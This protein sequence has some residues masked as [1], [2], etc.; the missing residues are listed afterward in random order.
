MALGFGRGSFFASL[1]PRK[2]RVSGLIRP[3]TRPSLEGC[4]SAFTNLLEIEPVFGEHGGLEPK[5][6]T[7]SPEGKCAWIEVYNSIEAKLARNGD[8]DTIRDAASK[9]AENVA[10]I[11]AIFHI[12]ENGADGDISHENVQRAAL[13][14]D[15]HLNEARRFFADIAASREERDAAKLEEWLIKTALEQ[16]TDRISRRD[17]DRGVFRARGGNHLDAAI[18]LLSKLGRARLIHGKNN[19]KDIEIRPSLLGGKS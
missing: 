17:A 14:V 19:K 18:K 8:Y 13:L 9:A 2:G 12:L 10:R 3:N 15:W 5:R 6:L 11:A 16:G 7:F 4:T 1:S